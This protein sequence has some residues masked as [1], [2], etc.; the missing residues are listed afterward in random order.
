MRSAIMQ[1]IVIVSGYFSPAHIGHIHYIREA[2]KLGDFL[3]AI[4]NNDE[5]VKIK[6]STPFMSENERLSII[7]AIRYVDEVFLSIDKDESVVKS[8][9]AVAKKYQG[10]LILARGADKNADNVPGSEKQFC[11]KFNIETIYGVG[12]EKIQSSS[13]LLNN[14][15]KDKA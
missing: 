12:G 3:V 11:K 8:L 6:G 2:K 4:V 13:W 1:K 7:K 14:V 9:E 15:I 10:Q 5:Q